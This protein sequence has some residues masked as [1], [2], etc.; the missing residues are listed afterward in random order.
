MIKHLLFIFLLG[1]TSLPNFAS[2]TLKLVSL[3]YPPYIEVVDNQVTGIA[4]T[5]IKEVFQSINQPISIEVLPWARAIAYVKK[6]R[7]DAI[8]TAFKTKEREVFLDYNQGV[9]FD[10][11]IRL[12][13]HSDYANSLSK[14]A[15]TSPDYSAY[16]LCI[17]N[18]VSYGPL[19]DEAIENREFK[20]VQRTMSSGSC[21]KMLEAKRIHI[22]VSNEFGAKND[23]AKLGFNESL[24]LLS[25]PIQVT[26]SY[27][28]FSKKK[29]HTLLIKEFDRVLKQFKDNGRYQEIV[30]SYF[31]KVRTKANSTADLIQN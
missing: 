21:A 23:I 11:K 13:V 19:I 25:P 27:I 17:V 8:F 10:Q 9:L 29:D 12:V 16:R 30:D 14:V 2:T 6:G 26:P 3:E 15:Q 20:Q 1:T 7:A 22:W 5:L 4:V 24:S 18:K 28:A 31:L